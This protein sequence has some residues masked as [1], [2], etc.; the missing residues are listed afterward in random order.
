[1]TLQRT[2]LI[3]LLSAVATIGFAAESENLAA[4]AK[5]KLA[6]KKVPLIAANIAQDAMGRD[7]NA[8]T[9]FDAKGE[10]P[11]GHGGKL[12]LARRLIKQVADRLE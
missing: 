8:I 2:C 6:K 3:V 10:H 12:E 1:M 5:A 7:D 4:N 11:L 9:L